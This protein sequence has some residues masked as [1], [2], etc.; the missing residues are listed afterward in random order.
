MLKFRNNRPK[1]FPDV[2]RRLQMRLQTGVDAIKLSNCHNLSLTISK[3]VCLIIP[4]T[5]IRLR[6]L[7]TSANMMKSGPSFQL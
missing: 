1:L 7:Q 6:H 3:L 4:N 2:Q 5:Y